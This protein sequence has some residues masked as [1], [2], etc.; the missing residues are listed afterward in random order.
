MVLR[1]LSHLALESQ[2]ISVSSSLLL[3]PNNQ[4]HWGFMKINVVYGIK[5]SALLLTGICSVSVAADSDFVKNW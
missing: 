1:V 3:N 4:C 5:H 2:P